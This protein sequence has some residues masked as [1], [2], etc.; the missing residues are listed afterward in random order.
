MRLLFR[1]ILSLIIFLPVQLLAQKIRTVSGEYIY[2]PPETQSL[3]EA[4]RIAEQ[5]V[6]IQLIADTFGTTISA[7]SFTSIRND[8]QRSETN[9]HSLSESSVKGE[10]IETTDGPHFNMS[11]SADG[12]L[13]ITVRISGRIREIRQSQAELLIKPLRNGTSARYESTSFKDGDDFYLSFQSPLNGWIT[14]YL[15]DGDDSVFRLLPYSRQ[16]EPSYAVNQNSPYIFFSVNLAKEN[17]RSFV[18]EYTLTCSKAIETNHLWCI[19]SPKPLIKVSDSEEGIGIPYSVSIKT[20]QR[21]LSRL[22][23]KDESIIV[24]QT[25]ITISK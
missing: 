3:D 1:F 17:E 5:R 20:F 16:A 22:V 8:N 18:D 2:Y 9:T 24:W 25:D 13:A 6:K 23:S 15:Y 10:W 7:S 12:M 4:K 11:A 19:F 21:W 14:V